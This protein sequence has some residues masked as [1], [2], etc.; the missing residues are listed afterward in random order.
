MR[1]DALCLPLLCGVRDLKSVTGRLDEVDGKGLETWLT[2]IY[3]SVLV[4][5]NPL[6]KAGQGKARQGEE[7]QEIIN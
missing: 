5:A 6:H 3:S 1:C 4:W 7:Q 2:T